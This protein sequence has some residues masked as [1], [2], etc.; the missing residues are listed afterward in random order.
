MHISLAG[1]LGSGK[2]TISKYLKEKYNFDIYSVGKIQRDLAGKLGLTILELNNLQQTDKHYDELIDKELILSSTENQDKDIIYDSRIAFKLL[3]DS[4]KVYTYINPDVAAQRVLLNT[5]RGSVEQYLNTQEARDKLLEREQSEKTKF[6]SLYST[7]ITDLNNYDLVLDTTFL[8]PEVLGDIIVSEASSVKGWN[9]K[10]L[11]LSPKSLYPTDKIQHI[12]E[13]ILKEYI[14]R[15]KTE[16]C[17]TIKV[18]YMNNNFYIVDGHHRWLAHLIN[19]SVT[20]ECELIS[21]SHNFAKPETLK[22]ELSY[23]GKSSLYDYEDAGNFRYIS[24]PEF[25]R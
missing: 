18:V 21:S 9:Y 19:D 13:N 15:I 3:G 16:D 20:V 25:Y 24:Y 2:S 8:T 14:T 17:A 11:I 23:V 10:K 6:K 1:K 5:E 22:K 12:D 4:F 7:D